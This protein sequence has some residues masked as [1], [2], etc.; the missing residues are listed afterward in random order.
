MAKPKPI[1][2]VLTEEEVNRFWSYVEKPAVGCWRWTK[3]VHKTGLPYGTIKLRRQM[4][5]ASRIAFF[6]SRNEDPWPLQVCHHCDNPSCCRPDHLFKGTPKENQE[7]MVRKGRSTT[8]DRNGNRKH[9][10]RTARGIR[11]HLAKLTD[12]RVIE[13]R[14]MYATGNYPYGLLSRMFKVHKKTARWAILGRTWKH[15]R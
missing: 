7:D 12:E 4:W 15:V 2:I 9:P 3:R 8:G 5:I 13:M 6:L 1:T 10:E 11:Q 14:E